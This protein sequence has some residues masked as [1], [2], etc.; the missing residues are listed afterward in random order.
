MRVATLLISLIFPLAVSIANGV[1]ICPALFVSWS[2]AHSFINQYR[3]SHLTKPGP[4]IP[5]VEAGFFIKGKLGGSTSEAFLAIDP[6]NQTSVVVK[7][8]ASVRGFWRE[9]AVTEYLLENGETVPKI[10]NAR[11]KKNGTV[12][13]IREYFKGLTGWE[14][15]RE[16][17][18]PNSSIPPELSV[19]AW[20]LLGPEIKRLENLFYGSNDRPSFQDWYF[21]NLDKLQEKYPE[22]WNAVK[23]KFTEDPNFLNDFSEENFLFDIERNIWVA[24]DP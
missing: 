4:H 16:R 12:I 21:A 23:V 22:V 14:L 17:N 2:D 5:K 15:S 10:L 6:A 9:L 8:G 3:E 13:V 18:S 7:I 11:I 20:Q 19:S 24:F 1:D